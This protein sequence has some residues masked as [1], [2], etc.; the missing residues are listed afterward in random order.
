[1]IRTALRRALVAVL[2][3]CTLAVPTTAA[4][5]PAGHP[6]Q[7]PTGV[8]VDPA[9][10][11]TGGGGSWTGGSALA[12]VPVP[13]VVV[14]RATDGTT[15]SYL[16]PETLGV[17]WLVDGRPVADVATRDGGYWRL[18]GRPGEA[19]DVV[20]AVAET[21][22]RL[23]LEDGTRSTAVAALDLRVAVEA[24]R[25]DAVDV[26]GA[27]DVYVVPDVPGLVV[28]DAEGTVLAPG[29]RHDVHGYVD[30]EAVVVLTLTAAPGHRLEVDGVPVEAIPGEGAPWLVELRFADTVAVEPVAPTFAAGDG[31]AGTV[32]IPA[33]DGL[34][35][36]VGD[37][38][39]EPGVH[40]A[41][42]T[43][44]VTARALD[45]YVVVG[46]AAWTHTFSAPGAVPD[47]PVVAPDLAAPVGG[48][49]RRGGGADGRP[50]AATGDDTSPVA[51]AAPQDEPAPAAL[52]PLT[53][54]VG[55]LVLGGLLLLR[56][57]RDQ[58]V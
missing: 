17:R 45:G 58:V 28:A 31:A 13:E 41:T 34:E 18:D 48:D 4:A 10:P 57:R 46:D 32:G 36:R 50:D 11:G 7:R 51:A 26:D 8:T 1:M 43:V 54:L 49:A 9:A 38:V 23:L 3:A 25:P 35:Y 24:V 42:G 37:V 15:T 21:G 39:A 30:H 12:D 52:D 40:A 19:P 20:V 56:G 29:S 14:R 55:G 6:T 47:A 16:L 53:L 33:V 27:P 22:H 44:S 2:V 5:S